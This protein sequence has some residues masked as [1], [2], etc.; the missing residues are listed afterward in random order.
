MIIKYLIPLMA[1]CGVGLAVRTVILAA[2]E[3]K[4]VPPLVE[5]AR[6]PFDSY[7][8]GAGIVEARTENVAIAATARGC[9][10]T[11]RKKKRS[12]RG[13]SAIA[14]MNCTGTTNADFETSMLSLRFAR[15][16]GL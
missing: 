5:P 7:L 8:S 10:L 2:E 4:V 16:G 15:L 3:P 9:T 12:T 11:I 1:M 6:A 14:G 13:E